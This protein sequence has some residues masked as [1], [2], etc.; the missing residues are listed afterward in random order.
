MNFTE[1]RTPKG[2]TLKIFYDKDKYLA[3]DSKGKSIY[4]DVEGK[5]MVHMVLLIVFL[6]DS[7]DFK[8]D[9]EKNYLLLKI[10]KGKIIIPFNIK[11]RIDPQYIF[12]PTDMKLD[13]V[14]A[15]L[16]RIKDIAEMVKDLDIH[17]IPDYILTD[18]SITSNDIIIVKNRYKI[19]EDVVIKVMENLSVPERK[20]PADDIEEK[21]I[22]LNLISENPVYLARIHL[23]AK[24]LSKIYQ[25]ILDFELT[26]LD[27]E[28]I[29]NFI[30]EQLKNSEKDLSSDKNRSMLLDLK[31][32]YAFYIK[33]LKKNDEGIRDMINAGSEV[34]EMAAYRT[35]ISKVKSIYPGSNEQIIYTE[36]ENSVIDKWEE[37][38]S[39]KNY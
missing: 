26:A 30:E 37:L 6:G 13:M 7:L 1:E 34:K 16:I 18:E 21:N 2:I 24:D 36:Y 20:Y 11:N 28:Y 38:K 10:Q 3:F 4:A 17:I 31:N 9:Y 33:L 29:L 19:D 8:K 5:V 32:L 35:L 22:N 12:L 23:R 14:P 39:Q 15:K 25:L 27:T